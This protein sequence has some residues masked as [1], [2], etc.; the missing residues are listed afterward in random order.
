MIADIADRCFGSHSTST[1]HTR[2]ASP[3]PNQIALNQWYPVVALPEI[4]DDLESLTYLLGEV[5]TYRRN[6]RGLAEASRLDGSVLPVRCDFGYLWTSLGDPPM[7]VFDEPASADAD[8]RSSNSCTL[9]IYTSAPRA[10]ENFIDMGHLPLIHAGLLGEMPYSEIVDYNLTVSKDEVLATQCLIYQPKESAAAT[11]GVLVDYTFRVPHPT[12]ALLY[13]TS[14]V[15]DQRPDIAGL[16][17]QPMQSDVIR[18]HLWDA[19]LDK[20]NSDGQIRR[21]G[22]TIIAQDRPVLENQMPRELPISRTQE[23]PVRSDKTGTAYRKWLYDMGW[24]YG[25]I[26]T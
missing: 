14:P 17:C 22:H 16:F 15:D 9:G 6:S 1:S 25:V 5:V 7:G 11:S 19:R 21:F 2:K 24:T 4:V 3:V 23:I 8:R 12:C 26:R 13:K 10:V 18:V 20:T